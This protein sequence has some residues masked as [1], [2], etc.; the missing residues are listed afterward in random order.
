MLKQKAT[1][2]GLFFVAFTFYFLFRNIDFKKLLDDLAYFKIIWIVPALAAYWLGYVI[3]GYR[4][5]ILL[6]PIKKCK[7]TSL[8]S[9]LII[10]FMMNNILPAR[11]GNFT[12]P[13]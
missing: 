11:L 9:T 5:V 4:W 7:F 8:F 2:I 13:T 3:R 1:W 10:G 12:G 6:S